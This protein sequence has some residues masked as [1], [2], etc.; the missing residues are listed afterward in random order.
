[1]EIDAM[2]TT[3][4]KDEPTKESQAKPVED[5][6]ASIR[7]VELEKLMDFSFIEVM[8]KQHVRVNGS[9]GLACS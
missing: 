5:T 6:T 3:P 1:M 2:S 7:T 4:P 8:A 9:I